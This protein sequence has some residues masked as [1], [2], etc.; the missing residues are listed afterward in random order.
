MFFDP[1]SIPDHESAD[2]VAW[3]RTMDAEKVEEFQYCALSWGDYNKELRWALMEGTTSGADIVTL[4]EAELF[5]EVAN[6]IFFGKLIVIRD[7]LDQSPQQWLV[8]PNRIALGQLDVNRRDASWS[9]R[10]NGQSQFAEQNSLPIDAPTTAP[11]PVPVVS[12]QHWIQI[13]V[14][15]DASGQ[16][17]RGVSMEITVPE[18]SK[19][20]SGP[21]QTNTAGKIEIMSLKSGTCK[22]TSPLPTSSMKELTFKNTLAY[23]A[24]GNASAS[25][26][27]QPA[28]P[29][30]GDYVI[31]DV[32]EYPIKAGDT[33]ASIASEQGVTEK[34]ITVFNWETTDAEKIKAHLIDDMGGTSRNDAS[35]EVVFD[36]S[37]R[38]GKLL[39]PRPWSLPSVRTMST[40]ILRV[41]SITLPQ[42]QTYFTIELR[43]ADNQ[44]IK[45]A[46]YQ[47]DIAGLDEPITGSSDGNGIINTQVPGPATEGILVVALDPEIPDQQLRFH[48]DIGPLDPVDATGG[49]QARF[50]NQNLYDGN[51]DGEAG[52]IT[53]N[54]INRY[55]Q[56]INAE[57]TE[58]LSADQQGQLKG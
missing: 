44:P 42:I 37:N 29:I 30:G 18:G 52:Q 28:K 3:S 16:P 48:V 20:T 51:I 58:Q 5:E 7:L 11:I 53:K 47:L 55:Q 12:Q 22:L 2:Y 34:D 31:A 23:I 45:N 57:P 32:E 33:L 27:N 26:N 56:S 1:S 41:K 9:R 40:A 36:D 14:V 25:T 15:E 50:A 10:A 13:D 39:I 6:Q 35:G 24:T 49:Q 8:S 17:I 4:S 21:Y 38:L 19:G 54:A 46:K 43:D